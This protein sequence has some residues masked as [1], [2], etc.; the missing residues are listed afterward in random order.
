MR[1]HDRACF[2]MFK[3][4]T[5]FKKPN[6]ADF[7]SAFQADSKALTLFNDLAGIMTALNTATGGQIS[8]TGDQRNGTTSKAMQ[9][10]TLLFMMR[11]LRKTAVAI[12]E[13]QN[14][15]ALLQNFHLTYS[16]ND[17]TLIANAD[18]FAAAAAP[19]QSSFVEF[20]HD[21]DFIQA[22]NNQIAAFKT[23]D[24][25]QNVGGQKRSGAT[26]SIGPLIHQGLA[27]VRQLDAI[28]FNK[29]MSNAERMG[30]WATAVHIEQHLSSKAQPAPEP[31]PT[32]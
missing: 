31:Q 29:Y 2:D 24:E 8:G 26:K 10:E 20:G 30:E 9:R 6:A 17:Q 13:A 5:D 15:P 27:V 23:A 22:L 21:P 12:S 18:A 1:D 16:N 28:M 7:K 11:G 25:S 19:I 4:V 3:R 14:N 32:T